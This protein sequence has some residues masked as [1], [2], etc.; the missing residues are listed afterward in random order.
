MLKT[1]T[2]QSSQTIWDI[3]NDKYG[4]FD[5]I[6]T[7]I[8][9]NPDYISIDV[10]LEDFIAVPLVYDDAYYTDKTPQVQ[11]SPPKYE[12]PIKQ[13]TGEANQSVYDLVLMVYG[14]INL[15]SKF[16][17]DNPGV[18]SSTNDLNVSGKTFNFDSRL[19]NDGALLA[20][21]EKRRYNFASFVEIVDESLFRVTDNYINRITDALEI[22]F[23]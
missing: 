18:I 21:I 14:D 15:M 23:V 3:A 16:I 7:L 8:Q 20:A 13:V 1:T 5:N 6:L 4:G 19:N 9:L 2:I 17:L 22:R 12:N 11:L 10:D